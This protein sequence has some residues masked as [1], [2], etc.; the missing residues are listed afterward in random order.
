MALDGIVLNQIV[1][2]LN[3]IVPCKIN[4]IQQVSDTEILFTVRANNTNHKLMISAH[5]TYKLSFS[6]SKSTAISFLGRI[7][8]SEVLKSFVLER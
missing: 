2:G 8:V 3:K 5:S 1:K 6:T 4:K 7:I